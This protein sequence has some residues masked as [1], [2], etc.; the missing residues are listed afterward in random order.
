MLVATFVSMFCVSSRNW[1]T[2]SYSVR[3]ILQLS[4]LSSYDGFL[5][6]SD[7]VEL[8]IADVGARLYSLPS[9]SLR[10]SLVSSWI[11]TNLNWRI[12]SVRSRLWEFLF[13]ALVLRQ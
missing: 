13:L 3:K 7:S 6:C 11:S 10:C 2:K 4:F 5:M 1:E 12:I 8:K 9:S